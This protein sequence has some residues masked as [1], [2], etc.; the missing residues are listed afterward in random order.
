[1]GI[2]SDEQ[3]DEMVAK[4]EAAA[5]G[6]GAPEVEAQADEPQQSDDSQD[7]KQAEDGQSSDTE[8]VKE[9]V[10]AQ[11]ES[12]GPEDAPK[13]PEHV[14]YG[15]FKEVNDK[16]R[17]REA[18]LQ[19]AMER[20]QALEQLTL[21]QAQQKTPP[22]PEKSDADAW[23]EELF[24]EE[25]EDPSAQ[26][27][28]QIRQ[29]MQSITEW[30]HKRTEQLVGAQLKAEIDAA[31]EGKPDVKEAEL[32]QAVAADGSIDV[33][34]AA[35]MIQKH[36]SEM[37]EQHRGEASS[38]IDALKAKIAEMENAQKEASSFRRPAATSA[39]PSQSS[40]RRTTVAEATS[41]FAEALRERMSH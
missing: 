14:P 11:V 41:A 18:E 40:T 4:M 1:M 20:V 27:L 30:Q 16:F 10:E 6:E 24:G 8:D 29:E 7:S 23:L 17:A 13:G 22:E 12:S 31:M 26:A 39:A 25:A 28:K 15:R 34:E 9:E 19:K 38:E 36:R 37:R 21:Q 5:S 3:Y 35:E 2:L 32:W 33:A